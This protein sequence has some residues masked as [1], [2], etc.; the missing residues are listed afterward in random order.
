MKVFMAAA[1]TLLCCFISSFTA[2]AD[3]AAYE[4]ELARQWKLM[5]RVP[6]VLSYPAPDAWSVY[7]M[8][9]T[10][11]LSVSEGGIGNK[12]LRLKIKAATPNP[13]DIGVLASTRV[14]VSKGDVVVAAFWARNNALKK[15]T[16]ETLLPAHLQDA[17]EPYAQFGTAKARLTSKW[18]VHY[19]YGTAPRNFKKGTMNLAL[20]VGDKRQTLEL[21]PVYLWSLGP[22]AIDAEDLPWESPGENP[23]LQTPV[24]KLVSTPTPP[25]NLS[26]DLASDL[27]DIR[28][29]VPH[30]AVLLNQP[31][32]SV[33]N[34]FG[35]D[36]AGRHV[37]DSGVPGG[38][39]FEVKVSR[40]GL[41]SWSAGIN[42]PMHTGISKGDT[43]LLAYW[44]RAV[45]VHN[46][47]Q[48]GNISAA[49]VQQSG[50]PYDSGANQSAS[51]DKTWRLYYAQGRSRSK[52]D[53]GGAG[54]SFHLGLAKQTIRVGPAYVLNYGP[55][56][57]P[58]ILPRT[59]LTY[60]GMEGDAEWRSG[61]LAN[62][63]KYRKANLKV[64][65]L[66]ASGGPAANAQVDIKMTK[67]AFN[68]GTFVG[69]EFVTGDGKKNETY[70][71]TFDDNF[72]TA[73]APLY[74]QDWGWNG[75][76]AKNYRTT[77]KYL[78][79]HKIAWRGHPIIWPGESYMPTNI[80]SAQ[81]NPRKQRQMVLDH[82]RDVMGFVK[83][84][85]P[86]AVDMVNEVRTN[87]YFSEQGDTD[88]INDAFK[89]AHEI[90]P[91]I[92]LFVNDYGILNS[93]GLN[94]KSIEFYHDW[95]QKAQRE[96]VPLGGIGFQAHFGAGLTPP[97]RVIE[98]LGEFAQYDLPLHI[99]EF[100][101]DTLDAAVQ[102][103]YTRDF[104]IAAFSQPQVDAFII[105][106]WWEGDHWKSSAAMLNKDWSERPN[107]ASWRDLVY[108]DWW[109]TET[110]TTDENGMA[111]VRAFKG[112]YE[113]SVNGKTVPYILTSDSFVSVTP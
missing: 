79:D 67:H 34:S 73:T 35:E 74:W 4:A 107:Y 99:T 24:A 101:V 59:Q 40:P 36:Q 77:A 60:E 93:G 44:A 5:P 108:G 113:I 54:I 51:L 13:W 17:N 32:V 83:G 85:N 64:Q 103:A 87:R 33:A 89:L 75:G 3:D 109:T 53:P 10:P 45:E 48:T 63:D 7:G 82:V 27:E 66:D 50:E 22:G 20:H 111:E 100:D 90:A 8:G 29:M 9:P 14:D 30:K 57:D 47:A 41:N 68:F 70:H 56:V 46:E 69:H 72:N 95:I 39:A 37:N 52:I 61:A 23:S 1:L 18:K 42:W 43:V 76:F 98:I 78:H 31:D 49:R 58:K 62:I 6:S 12:A 105:W 80:K 28:A 16:D 106:G 81:G 94:L 92:P 2:H 55:N 97:A 15:D 86:I 65:V 25:E 21:G 84:L 26:A 11:K 19:V 110:V 91:D 71:Q 88:L 104:L 102:A 38:R 96:N 112:D